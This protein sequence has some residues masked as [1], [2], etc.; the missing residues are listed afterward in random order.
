[1]NQPLRPSPLDLTPNNPPSTPRSPPPVPDGV[2]APNFDA[3]LS[4][5]GPVS[6]PASAPTGRS[7]QG[8]FDGVSRIFVE[9]VSPEAADELRRIP[10]GA[11]ILGT[12]I[13]GG[14]V[15]IGAPLSALL[16]PGMALGII[17]FGWAYAA[18]ILRN[19]SSLWTFVPDR[20]TEFVRFQL[21]EFVSWRRVLPA[22]ALSITVGISIFV[23]LGLLAAV[24]TPLFLL[25]APALAWLGCNVVALLGLRDAIPRLLTS[26]L[27]MEYGFPTKTTLLD[28]ACDANANSLLPH[29]EQVAGVLDGFGSWN[30]LSV[31]GG[32]AVSVVMKQS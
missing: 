24:V 23:I 6:G 19:A 16:R 9:L 8:A 7:G 5:G 10:G 29:I 31:H 15:E 18:V 21:S 20:R 22:L 17:L 3:G 2:H 12:R 25:V 1:M 14:R 26:R 27:T 4:N 28:L 30:H 11:V 13:V 32:A